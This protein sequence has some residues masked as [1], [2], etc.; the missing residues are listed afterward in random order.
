MTVLAVKIKN[1]LFSA[2]R[3]GGLTNPSMHGDSLMAPQHPRKPTTIIR[4]PAAIRMYTPTEQRGTHEEVFLHIPDLTM[5]SLV[6]KMTVKVG[7]CCVIPV[8]EPNPPQQS[9]QQH[10]SLPAMLTE[11]CTKLY[12]YM[13]NNTRL[14]QIIL[15]FSSATFACSI[16]ASLF[17]GTDVTPL[18]RIMTIQADTT[19]ES[20]CCV[21]DVVMNHI[22]QNISKTSRKYHCGNA[23]M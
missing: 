17:Q 19:Q 2:E 22:Q 13:N 21:L 10:H 1:D 3:K 7:F 9:R 6:R 5:V 8:W 4:A 18:L 11:I 14:T 23:A 20:R 15:Q 12:P 16:K